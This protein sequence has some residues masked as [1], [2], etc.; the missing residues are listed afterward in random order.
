M[1]SAKQ[2]M[3][4]LYF[5]IC[6]S[7]SGE[8]PCVNS[9]KLLS[10]TE[11]SSNMTMSTEVVHAGMASSTHIKVAN[12][13]IEISRCSMTVSPSIPNASEGRNHNTRA[14]TI[15]TANLIPRATV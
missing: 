8:K 2:C 9:H 6:P 12:T 14:T 15:A 7:S 4:D 1:G 5:T 13:K 10:D 3:M 11:S